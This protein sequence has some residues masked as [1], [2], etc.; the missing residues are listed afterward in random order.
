[1]QKISVIYLLG[2]GQN[3]FSEKSKY[4]LAMLFSENL[5][6]NESVT[7]LDHTLEGI[8]AKHGYNKV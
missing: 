5:M 1:M 3:V 4:F 2:S 8:Q 6:T 7:L